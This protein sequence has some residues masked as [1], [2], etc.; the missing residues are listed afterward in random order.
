MARPTGNITCLAC[1]IARNQRLLCRPHYAN[2]GALPDSGGHRIGTAG[3][4]GTFSHGLQSETRPRIAPAR[5]RA[6]IESFSVILDGE[7]EGG[8]FVMQAD[9]DAV[10]VGVLDCIADRLLQ[11]AKDRELERL[12]HVFFD[13]ADMRLHPGTRIGDFEFADEP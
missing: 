5:Q 12:G 8:V 13:D 11:D 9:A 6:R 3:E 1:A 2:L 10:R 4:L 7:G